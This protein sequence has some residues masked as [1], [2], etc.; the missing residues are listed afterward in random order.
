MDT[1]KTPDPVAEAEKQKLMEGVDQTAP[2]KL[3]APAKESTDQFRQIGDQISGF[4]SELPD[5][6]GQFF[7][8]YQ[9]PLTTVGLFI[10]AIVAVKVTLAILDAINDIPLLAPLFE[11]VG[12]GYTSWFVYRYLLRAANRAEL[13]QEFKS[14]KGQVIGQ[15]SLN[16]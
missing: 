9:R 16:S 14:L 11:L 2:G 15:S 7:S 4:L 12:I 13:N 10:G 6:L 1:I 3:L 5:Y 8:T